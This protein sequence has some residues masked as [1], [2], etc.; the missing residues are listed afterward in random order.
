MDVLNGPN[1][2]ICTNVKKT[3]LRDAKTAALPAKTT[4]LLHARTVALPAKTIALPPVKTV[5]LM[6]RT[7]TGLAE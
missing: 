4:A 7:D 1:P 3:A 2:G 5:P 6:E